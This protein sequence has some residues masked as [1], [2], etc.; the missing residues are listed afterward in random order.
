VQL[1]TFGETGVRQ[2][3]HGRTRTRSPFSIAS[4]AIGRLAPSRRLP[5]D[6]ASVAGFT[7]HRSKYQ[8]DRAITIVRRA[9]YVGLGTYVLQDPKCLQSLNQK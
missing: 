1:A 6:S 9:D 4:Q 7:E 2:A 3:S 8:R 5:F